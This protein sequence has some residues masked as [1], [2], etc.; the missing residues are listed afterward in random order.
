MYSDNVVTH[1][2]HNKWPGEDYKVFETNRYIFLVHNKF[3]QEEIDN[4]LSHPDDKTHQ[5]LT[6]LE[7]LSDLIIDK[8]E[9]KIIKSRN[10]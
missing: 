8:E 2:P 3:S 4:L 5:I 1:G 7:Y 9:R 10:F 6:S